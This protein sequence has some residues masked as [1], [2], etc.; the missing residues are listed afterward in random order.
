[1]VRTNRPTGLLTTLGEIEVPINRKARRDRESGYRVNYIQLYF[2][3]GI[4]GGI[5][6]ASFFAAY[7]F[8]G[9]YV[10]NDATLYALAIIG[11]A[12]MALA[13]TARIQTAKA[14]CTHTQIWKKA[15]AWFG[16]LC[17][18]FITT[19][20]M[21]QV[22]EQIY[23]PRLIGVVRATDELARA[24]GQLATLVADKEAKAAIM[25]PLADDVARLDKQ[26]GELGATIQSIG[27]AP[28]AYT[29][30]EN[31]VGTCRNKKGQTHQCTKTRSKLVQPEYAGTSVIGQIGNVQEQ[32]AGAAKARDE[33]AKVVADSDVLIANQQMKVTEL[34]SVRREAVLQSQLHSFTAMVFGKDPTAV[35]DDEVHWFLRFFVLVT[36]AGIAVASTILVVTAYHPIPKALPPKPAKT[37][38]KEVVMSPTLENHVR[39]IATMSNNNVTPIRETKP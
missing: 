36:A 25:K 21:S 11:A 1:L 20:A 34:E 14:I 7:E 30:K 12:S 6:I 8:A 15:I 19:K 33:A 2:A 39:R 38:R 35:T 29:V 37:V 16:V 17:C 23:S 31:Y 24:K 26:V 18:I 3:Y 13:E 9:R 4:E 22:T 10:S 27:A 5:I 32:R 28:K